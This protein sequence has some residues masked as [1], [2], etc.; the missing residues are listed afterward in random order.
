MPT[1]LVILAVYFLANFWLIGRLFFALQGAGVFRVVFCLVPVLLLSAYP[2]S[3][4][5]DGNGILERTFAFAG[6]FWIGLALYAF[7]LLLAVDLFRLLN[8]VFYWFPQLIDGAPAIRYAACAAIAGG[9]LLI[10]LA[11]WVNTRWPVLREIEISVPRAGFASPPDTLTVAAISDIHLGRV[12]SAA[13]F[14]KLVGLI[15][16]RHPDLVLFL[17]DVIDDFPGLDEEAMKTTLARLSPPLGVWGILGN[18][19]YIAGDAE[20]SVRILERSGIRMLRDGWA[21]PGGK[22]LLVGRDDRSIERFNG[23][24]RAELPDLMATVPGEQRRLPFILLDHQ[25]FHLEEAEQAGALLQLSGH[26][27][28]GQLFPANFVVGALYE[29][30]Y[31]PSRRGATNYWVSGGGGTWGPPVRTVG[32]S[33]VLL[34]TLRFV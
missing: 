2:L 17:G 26:T 4:M 11:G 29:N 19:E 20:R 31:G 10:C 1:F 32:R 25:P 15:E 21:A 22:V 23:K 28:N 5:S 18:H 14:D 34:I 30:A 33:E 9:A 13:H 3:R 12:V 7:L 27:H 24:H 6:S 8:R 16:P